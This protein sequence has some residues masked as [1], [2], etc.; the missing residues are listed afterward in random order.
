[1]FE[2]FTDRA[3]KAMALANQEALRLGHGYIDTGHILLGLMKEGSGV[4]AATLKSL[5]VDL[6]EARREVAVSLEAAPEIVTTGKLPQTPRA[7]RVIE[8]AIEESRDLGHNYVGTEHLLLGLLRVEDGTAAQVLV[9]L[10]VQ[11]D[12][13]RAQV[14]ALTGHDTPTVHTTEVTAE[15]VN[16][17][18]LAEGPAR[19]A[20]TDVLGQFLMTS[21]VQLTLR[22]DKAA[23][24][25]RHEVAGQM[26]EMAEALRGIL[27]RLT[28][29][30]EH[31]GAD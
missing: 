6:K 26:R 11:L 2:R 24:R 15:Q 16:L 14:I 17:P 8:Y 13:A 28:G 22:A 19:F 4:G 10:G 18:A 20:R 27:E 1:M 7:K 12:Q 23:A 5:G 31:E 3:R 9:K 30:A 21:I 25:G 29:L